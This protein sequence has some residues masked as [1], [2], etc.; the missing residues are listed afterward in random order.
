M[1]LAHH[2][3][4]SRNHNPHQHY[5]STT[6]ATNDQSHNFQSS[7]PLSTLDH[8]PAA[9]AAIAA[10]QRYRT[11]AAQTQS[12]QGFDSGNNGSQRLSQV[13]ELMSSSDPWMLHGQ[14]TPKATHRFG[15]QRESSLSSLGSNGPASPYN[16]NTSNPQI[17]VADSNTDGYQ[18]IGG[19]EGHYSYHLGKPLAMNDNFYASTPANFNNNNHSNNNNHRH[20]RSS[21][22]NNQNTNSDDLNGQHT[23]SG[24][25]FCDGLP[26][27]SAQQHKLRNERGL[28]PAP[29][30]PNGGSSIKSH[31]VS[32]ASSITGGDSPATP[33]Y[34]EA[35][36][37]SRRPKNVYTNNNH[38]LPK[39]DRT[40]TD[41]YNDELFNPNV[42][43]TSASPPPQTRLVMSPSSEIFAQRLQAA[44]SQHLSAVQSPVSNS[45]SDR[46]PFRQGSP[47][48]SVVNEFPQVALDQVRLGSAQQIRQKNKAQQDAN[49]LQ[50]QMA[51]NSGQQQGTPNTISPKDAVL[52]FNESEDGSNFPL[53]PPQEAN[54]FNIGPA[55]SSNHAASSSA[56]FQ[57]TPSATS[58]HNGFNFSMPSNVQ[59]PQ[60]YPFIARH[61]QQSTPS[62]STFSRVSSAEASGSDG[63]DGTAQ[64]PSRT[65]ADGGTYTCTY[66]GCTLRFETPALL[67]KH[68]REGHRQANT[69]QQVRGSPSTGVPGSIM[70]SQAGPHRCDRINPSTGKPCNTVFSR[71]YDL[72]RHED[73][74]HNARKQKVRCDLCTEEKTFSRADAL[75]RHYRVC[76]PDVE[77][78]GKH[79]RRGGIGI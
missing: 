43:F 2:G 41:I 31:P 30:F 22:G 19:G 47:Y 56:S 55:G 54:N 48:A 42:T 73:T 18:D 29:E 33:S 37:D 58:M 16:A 27:M 12:Q 7:T 78:P 70:N 14:Q 26:N 61:Q 76:H 15:H 49:E 62:A 35:E 63:S 60:Q 51:R 52:D 9:A 65:N 44:N 28:A 32:V 64:R 69:L 20:N 38:N 34:N 66:H 17:A 40:M 25:P 71:P 13:P 3:Y 6:N 4:P 74:I 50:Q 45:S 79:R 11:P 72:T 77:F 53:F 10:S 21:S 68:K 59:V 39:L 46:S 8:I 1:M 36:D 57:A 23:A 5:S 75:T 24:V 67:Q